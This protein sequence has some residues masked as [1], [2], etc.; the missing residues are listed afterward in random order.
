MLVFS[1]IYYLLKKLYWLHL[2]EKPPSNLYLC[3]MSAWGPVLHS[4]GFE[5][6]C[7][8]QSCYVADGLLGHMVILFSPWGPPL[9]PAQHKRLGQTSARWWW[10]DPASRQQ[11]PWV[12]SSARGRL[13]APETSWAWQGAAGLWLIKGIMYK[14]ASLLSPSPATVPGFFS[15]LS[16]TSYIQGL[17]N[18]ILLSYNEFMPT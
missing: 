5:Q 2:F 15:I 17:S 4:P 13:C 18:S 9:A 10:L 3:A 16:S 7:Q 8:M 1:S 6:T 14:D 11:L 12:R